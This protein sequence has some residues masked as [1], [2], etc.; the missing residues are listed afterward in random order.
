[1][2]GTLLKLGVAK[3]HHRLKWWGVLPAMEQG[4]EALG[5]GIRLTGVL[6]M[7]VPMR[8][9]PMNPMRFIHQKCVCGL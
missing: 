5:A 7:P 4:Y 9:R 1:M 8:S 3:A 2:V 6:D